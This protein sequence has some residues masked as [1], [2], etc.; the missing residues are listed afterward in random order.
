MKKI[1]IIEQFNT[2]YYDHQ[3][4]RFAAI[5]AVDYGYSSKIKKYK[6]GNIV[7]AENNEAV[8]FLP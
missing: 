1:K 7:V 2:K 5:L 8:A 4:R 3:S 6:N